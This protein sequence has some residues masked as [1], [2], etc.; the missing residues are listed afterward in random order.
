MN[1]S[2]IHLVAGYGFE[3]YTCNAVDSV[4]E[5]TRDDLVLL[6]ST[7]GDTRLLQER[8]AHNKRIVF[9]RVGHEDSG[10]TGSLYKAYAHALNFAKSANARYLNIL[11]NDMQL[12]WWDSE[13]LER[14]I[15]VF[16]TIEN[17][18]FVHTGFTRFG[19]HPDIYDQR[20][21]TNITNSG[22]LCYLDR[23][24]GWY[25]WG[26]YDIRRLTQEN[27]D[28]N[29]YEHSLSRHLRERGYICVYS[30]IPITVPIP[31]PA[32]LRGG[33]IMGKE[34]K[35]RD[36]PFLVPKRDDALSLL[37]SQRHDTLF[38]EDWVT[39][40]GWW[41]LEPIWATTLSSEYLEIRSRL[42]PSRRRPIRW[43]SNNKTMMWPPDEAL[44]FPPVRE[45]VDMHKVKPS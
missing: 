8:Y 17:C 34:L 10:K 44:A 26:L 23:S 28:I 37:K 1:R 32:T 42:H 45:I 24:N 15:D 9:T 38:Q 4:L 21:K 30:S 18:L 25:D 41:S 5:N 2:T 36:L 3:Q 12:L 19:S 13:I 7:G 11:Q 39:S 22:H 40:N 6:T 33:L 27:I 14:Y 29:G 35:Y 43:V 31:W 20:L 16:D